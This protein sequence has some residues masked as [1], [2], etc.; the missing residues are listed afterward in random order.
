M[1]TKQAGVQQTSG[2]CAEVNSGNTE[3]SITSLDTPTN[4]MDHRGTMVDH[5]LVL[6]V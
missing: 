1:Q 3:G 5:A 2:N 4:G 6:L